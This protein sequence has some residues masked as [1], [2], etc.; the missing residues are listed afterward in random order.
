MG[1]LLHYLSNIRKKQGH[2]NPKGDPDA[3]HRAARSTPLRSAQDDT[4][5]GCVVE[6]GN[7]LYPSRC[8]L[9]AYFFFRERKSKFSFLKE[10]VGD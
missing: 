9:F 2:G 7:P 6:G 10:K 1:Y 5:S 4:L 8:F 3:S